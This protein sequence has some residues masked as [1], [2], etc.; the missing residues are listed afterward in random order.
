MRS[1]AE[2]TQRAG[3]AAAWRRDASR[4]VN[5]RKAARLLK[6]SAKAEAGYVRN[7]LR[8]MRAVHAGF[9]GSI[10]ESSAL[11][12]RA[13]GHSDA[14][15]LPRPF[16]HGMQKRLFVYIRDH[17]GPA[18]DGMAREV[19]RDNVEGLALL[20][21]QPAYVPGLA[22]TIAHAREDNVRLIQKAAGD[23]ADQ[24]QAVLTDPANLGLRHEELRDL[25]VERGNV[26]VSRASFIARDQTLRLN[27]AI[28][29]SRQQAA[30]VLRYTWST[31]QD[32]RVRPMHAELE[33]LAFDYDDPP[34]T[35]EEGDTNNPGE[36]YQCRCVA[37]PVIPELEEEEPPEEEEEPAPE[38]EEIPEVPEVP[39]VP[40][41]EELPE[42]EE[43]PEVPG[44]PE[45]AAEPDYE[46]ISA[47][48]EHVRKIIAVEG[49]IDP[50]VF[51]ALWAEAEKAAAGRDELLEELAA[52]AP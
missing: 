33:G 28:T 26:S 20:G 7:V 18:F 34:V 4:P 49:E 1:A 43:V 23:Y 13:A 38:E 21:I 36:D 17:V 14:R 16:P 10:G 35:N 42:L 45:L 51:R 5:R 11:E 22:G 37:I 2:K 32:E 46:A 47:I 44:V 52:M 27:A 31:S 3:F 12:S 30:G 41:L 50:H 9:L 39:E 40:E 48:E 29:K 25:L 24:V 6:A 15:P 8:V 19:N